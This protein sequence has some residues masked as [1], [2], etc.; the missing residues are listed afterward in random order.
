MF[1]KRDR[2]TVR[3]D[4]QTANNHETDAAPPPSKRPKPNP[5]HFSTLSG[6]FSGL[7]AEDPDKRL[8]AAKDLMSFLVPG[9]D[10]V[11][12]PDT[13]EYVLYRLVRGLCSP[14]KAARYGY[15]VALTEVLGTLLGPRGRGA[16]H[17][18]GRVVAQTASVRKAVEMVAKYSVPE[19][20][21]D[22]TDRSN[23]LI[24]RVFGYKAVLQSGILFAGK[25]PGEEWKEV[26]DA[27][28]ELARQ[29]P[30]LRVECGMVLY[31]T[32]AELAKKPAG[33]VPF[34]ESMIKIL[35]ERGLSK[36]AE[37]VAVWIA[38]KKAFPDA[39]FPKHV[40]HKR[41][42]LCSNEWQQ[43]ATVMRGDFSKFGGEDSKELRVKGGSSEPFL[44]FSYVAVVNS[45]LERC[46]CEPKEGSKATSTFSKFWVDIVD[47]NLFSTS[48]SLEKKSWGFQLLSKMLPL[49]PE[50][51]IDSLFSPNLMRV[52]INHLTGKERYLHQSAKAP[53]SA[54]TKRAKDDG[55]VAAIIVKRLLE[56]GAFNFDHLTK[57]KTVEGIVEAADDSARSQLVLL[58]RSYLMRPPSLDGVSAETVRRVATDLLVT[59]V[60]TSNKLPL[61][62]DNG[63]TSDNWMRII[64]ETF[65]KLGYFRPS[66][67]LS[68]KDMDNV[69][70]PPLSDEERSM[71]H[72]RFTSCIRSLLATDMK[73][74]LPYLT[75]GIRLMS[76]WNSSDS[77]DMQLVLEADQRVHDTLMQARRAVDS[78]ERLCEQ[79]EGTKKAF[80]PE[81]TLLYVLNIFEAYSGDTDAVTVLDDIK[82][83]DEWE[84]E[85]EES[86]S[87]LI[88]LLLGF[89]SK[90]SALFR[91]MAEIVFSRLGP[92]WTEENL[93]ALSDLLEKKENLEGQQE[94][95]DRQDEVDM[96]VDVEES[97]VEEIDGEKSSVPSDS[98][99][100][101]QDEAQDDAGEESAP[102][103]DNRRL[104]SIDSE[105]D[106]LLEKKIAELLK[107]AP[108]VSRKAEDGL[109]D[110]GHDFERSTQ[111]TEAGVGSGDTEDSDDADMDDEQMM[112]L[113]PLLTRVFQERKKKQTKRK[114]KKDAQETMIN[115]KNRVLDLLT[116]YLKEQHSNGLSRTL[117]LP[118]L[119]LIR[120][121]SSQQIR[122][123]AS[124]MLQQYYTLC[125]KKG[126]PGHGDPRSLSLL[127]WIHEEALNTGPKTHGNACT[128]ASLFF[129]RN[130]MSSCDS[131]I[132]VIVDLYASTQK[133]WLKNSKGSLQPAFFVEWV[134][135]LAE[136]R[137]R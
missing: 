53:L 133:K 92:I 24:G 99:D 10:T 97:D 50:E 61:M 118:L 68:R 66:K 135:W 83:I 49:A 36:T 7:A 56:M 13:V 44:P 57:T 28:C 116:I 85:N 111:K 16:R 124:N 93:R 18:D 37:G 21:A 79:P 1:R 76:A 41:D 42:P 63:N 27:I 34:A 38:A 35:N 6:F 74:R 90:Q 8:T 106:P 26:L 134:N 122:N 137:R 104:E 95:F 30:W 3:T 5:D 129:A 136:F 19:G 131:N 88:E 46:L 78:L 70:I 64:I 125:K 15:F 132:E 84:V 121:T 65:V 77:T 75:L 73:E 81:L 4:S 82:Q 47:N 60:R 128:K 115:F 25:A 113:D 69:S 58:F 110:H 98:T 126:G 2:T 101:T 86:R 105:A 51:V 33:R 109:L 127:E 120:T 87:L 43:L 54:M 40:W 119:R 31:E 23:H 62:D 59:V 55:A 52:L 9:R 117:I 130:Y 22:K 114:E 108:K 123:K 14:A 45:M 17:T 32:V 48:A 91:K 39:H 12:D 71:I 72:S 67:G 96:D 89:L 102:Q 94:L 103:D 80:I 20:K 29:T 112:A 100:E 11:A 107:V